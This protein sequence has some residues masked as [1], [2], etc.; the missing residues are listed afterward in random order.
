MSLEQC[1]IVR[2][3]VTLYGD[4]GHRTAAGEMA[5]QVLMDGQVLNLQFTAAK[6]AC[7]ACASPP[8]LMN[9]KERRWL[10]RA[11]AFGLNP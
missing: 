10:R 6:V 9:A 7:R 5:Q 1:A 4:C 11:V 8:P 3:H 2:L